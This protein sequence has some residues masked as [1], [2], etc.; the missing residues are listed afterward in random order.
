M[1]TALPI[2]EK[3]RWWPN[4]ALSD[5]DVMIALILNDPTTLDLIQ[6]ILF[7]GIDR[8]DAVRTATASERSEAEN[9]VLCLMYDPVREGV[10]EAGEHSHDKASD[11]H[12]SPVSPPMIDP[13]DAN[14]SGFLKSA[15]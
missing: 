12:G 2:F 13:P 11:W 1:T 10:R 4:A 6:T 7:W 15:P 5:S 14:A 8:V 3:N 9:H